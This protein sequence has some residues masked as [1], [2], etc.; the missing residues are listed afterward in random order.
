MQRWLKRVMPARSTL[1]RHWC[2]KHFT[3]HL[4]ERGC[5]NFHRH[6]VIRSFA[7]G[8]FIAFI[9][10]TP[11]LPVH[12]VTCAILGL[13]FRLNL[14]VLFATVF[15]SNPFTW[16]P[17]IAGSLWVG[18]KLL[19]M[20]LMPFLHAVSHET[21]WSDIRELWAPLLLGA[22]VLGVVAA[23]V[24]YLPASLAWG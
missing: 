2:L 10:P 12:L 22:L 24:G 3:A 4:L 7:L 17:Q 20:D 11:L 23:A 13:Y 1:E 15:V 14:P 9:P 18:A 19:G 21:F 8:L 16:V 5:W 6:S